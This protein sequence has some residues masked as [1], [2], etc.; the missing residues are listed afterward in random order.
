M[1]SWRPFLQEYTVEQLMGKGN[2]RISG[3]SYTSTMHEETA[4]AFSAM[5]KAA[6]KD[7]IEIEI[8]SAYRSFKRQKEIYENKYKQFTAQGLSGPE[9]IQKIIAYSTIPGTSRHHWGTDLDL[10]DA[11]APRPQSV[12]LEANYHGKGPYCKLREWLV[13]NAADFD[14]YEVY[15]DNPNRK[16]FEYEPWHYSYAPV[17]V[18]MLKAYRKLDLKELLSSEELLGSEHLTDEFLNKYMKEHIL[19][20]N[21]ILL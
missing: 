3:D 8:V 7:G 11:A 2:P 10:I 12:L 17:S 1:I 18:P 16:G 14:F 9:A 13:K 6:L 21:P 20:I 19:D 15:T 4:E 5:R